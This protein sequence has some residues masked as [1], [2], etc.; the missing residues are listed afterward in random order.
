MCLS[1]AT[2]GS[3]AGIQEDFCRTTMA[4]EGANFLLFYSYV[5]NMISFLFRRLMI[6]VL[7]I[8]YSSRF[9]MLRMTSTG[10]G[11][12]KMLWLVELGCW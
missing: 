9:Y 7:F 11:M 8:Y 2:S 10:A 3:R 12:L 1:T 6:M 4:A 5:I